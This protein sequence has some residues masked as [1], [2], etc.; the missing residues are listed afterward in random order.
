MKK[1]TKLTLILGLAL[2]SAACLAQDT[3]P[4]VDGAPATAQAEVVPL[5]VIDEAPLIEAVKT[6]A[7][8]ANINFILDPR[9]TNPDPGPDGKVPV[10]PNVTIRFEN[11]TAEDALVSVLDTYGLTMV[12]DPRTKVARITIKDPDALAPLVTRVVQ[13]NYANATNLVGVLVPTLVDKRSRVLADGRTRKL[14]IVATEKDQEAGAELIKKLDLKTEQVLIEGAIVETSKNPKSVKGIDWTGTLSAQNFSYGNNPLGGVTMETDGDTLKFNPQTGFLR[15]DGVSAVLS[16][17]NTQTDAEVMSTPRTV[18][19]DNQAA[20]LEVTRAFP[21]F[22][23]TPGSAN[24]PAGAEI[25]Y[26]N[27][28]TILTVTPRIA[29]D[30]NVSLSVTPEVSN[31]AG[32]DSQLVPASE[33]SDSQVITA[34]IYDIRRFDTTVLVPSGNTIVLGGL[35]TEE[36]ADKAT[37]VPLLG[38]LP[39]VG[40]AFRS[41]SK[42]RTKKNLLVFLTPTILREDDFQ[43]SESGKKFMQSSAHGPAEWDDSDAWESAKP[44]DWRKP[45]Y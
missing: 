21:I 9:L 34:N 10:P 39:G 12:R 4:P 23:V 14:I 20:K 43:K 18:T 16:F 7:R 27:L 17:L 3:T 38:D 28:G 37:K 15:A 6:L 32:K 26:T 25:T 22:K 44:H 41:N 45:V 42:E 13:L 24:S 2:G 8:Q 36:V 11:V 29:A 1:T 35:V 31:L 19:L 30:N 5:I 33:G 40:R